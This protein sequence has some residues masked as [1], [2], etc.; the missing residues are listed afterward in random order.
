MKV[1][2]RHHFERYWI[3][4]P[5]TLQPHHKL[6]GTNVLVDTTDYTCYFLE[7]AIISMLIDPLCLSKGWIHGERN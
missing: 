4:Q 5:S 6:H 3:N 7:G 2:L 1:I